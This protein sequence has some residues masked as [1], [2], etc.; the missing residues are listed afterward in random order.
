MDELNEGNMEC[1][2]HYM[3]QQ[4]QNEPIRTFF[5]LHA[6]VM[7]SIGKMNRLELPLWMFLHAVIMGRA[8]KLRE[9]TL[10]R[11]PTSWDGAQ[12]NILPFYGLGSCKKSV[13]YITI[14]LNLTAL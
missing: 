2:W 12:D 10:Y 9:V 4:R 14:A 7:T 8:M 13:P 5:H 6:E 3:G 1:W 11:C